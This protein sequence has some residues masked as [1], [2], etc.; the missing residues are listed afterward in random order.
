[1]TNRGWTL[2]TAH[3]AYIHMNKIGFLVI[4]HT[5]TLHGQ[6]GIA[7]LGCRYSRN[8]NINGFGFDVLAVQRNARSAFAEI[9]VARR[10]TIAA[11][12]VDFAVGAS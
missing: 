8:A 3:S 12:D 6:G 1:M 9:A 4:A 5:P 10:T 2:P 7:N 11:Y